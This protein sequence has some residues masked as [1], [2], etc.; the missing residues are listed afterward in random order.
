MDRFRDHAHRSSFPPFGPPFWALLMA[1]NILS[2]IPPLSCTSFAF[3]R[4]AA[5]RD[6]VTRRPRGRG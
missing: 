5:L 4:R 6:V 2:I 3:F 1:A